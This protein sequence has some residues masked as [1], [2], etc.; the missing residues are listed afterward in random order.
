MSSIQIYNGSGTSDVCVQ[1]WQREI[2]ANV[3]LR[4]YKLEFFNRNDSSGFDRGNVALV[5]IPGGHAVKMT[6]ELEEL[7]GKIKSAVYNDSFSFL[8]S[9]AGAVVCAQFL[10]AGYS[11]LNSHVN[12]SQFSGLDFNPLDTTAPYYLPNTQS[13]S[14]PTNECA[15]EVEWPG[16]RRSR[17]YYGFGPAFSKKKLNAIDPYESRVL[18]TYITSGCMKAADEPVAAV[19]FQRPSSMYSVYSVLLTGIHPEIGLEDI[20]SRA[21][22]AQFTHANADHPQFLASQLFPCEAERKEICRSWLKILGLQ[23]NK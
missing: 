18:A 3:D 5:L 2:N 14:D 10:T 7:S 4:N 8:G 16:N 23:L 1:A 6:D 9:C 21:F 11:K 13:T 15:I 12:F 20:S 22:A 19:S 17:S